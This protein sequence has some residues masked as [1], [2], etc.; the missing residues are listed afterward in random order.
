MDI[1]AGTRQVL[2]DLLEDGR[3]A[4]F[5]L[6]YS[7]IGGSRW[8]PRAVRR[9][10]YTAGGASMQS[11]PGPAF[12]FAGQPS[13]LRLGQG[14]FMNQGVFIDA[15]AAV[16]VGD[17]VLLGMGAMIITSHHEIRDGA[18]DPLGTGVPVRIGDRVWIGARALVLP[19]TVIE[20]DVVIAAGAVVRGHCA[21][22]G[23]YAGVPARRIRETAPDQS[24]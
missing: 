9:A 22:H 19:G 3:V 14:I 23:L 11:A 20:H 13:H 17:R 12:T 10:V 5:H 18:I 8:L 7:S 21:A 16:D 1:G 2:R 15:A 4:G 24:R 6:V